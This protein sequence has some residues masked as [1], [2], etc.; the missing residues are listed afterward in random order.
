[1][2]KRLLAI[3]LLLAI[4]PLHSEAAI[5]LIAGSR[6]TAGSTTGNNITTTAIDT[7][8]ANLIVVGSA[9]LKNGPITVTDSKSNGAP[10]ALT[11]QAGA[12]IQEVRI[13]YWHLPASV[14]AGHTF[15]ITSSGKVPSICVAAFSGVKAS[16][17]VDQQSGVGT[18]AG[19]GTSVQPGSLTPSEDNCLVISC[20]NFFGTNGSIND[21]FD[22]STTPAVGGQHF[23]ILMGD[24][25][26]T[27]ATAVNPTTSWTTSAEKTAAMV[28][29][30]AEPTGKPLYYYQQSINRL[31][32]PTLATSY[33]LA[34]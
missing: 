5:A 6:T 26:Q 17:P 23:G 9:Y 33:Q 29:F 22:S 24:K 14:G 11:L 25:I 30:K 3:L 19:S 21:S 16:S 1:M 10:T 13:Y 4:S 15:T 27:T 20:A 31:F 28:V 12:S 34:P 2:M 18:G 32:R 7:T 8:G